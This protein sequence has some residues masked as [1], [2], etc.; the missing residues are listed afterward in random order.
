VGNRGDHLADTALAWNEAPSS[1]FFN[2]VNQYGSNQYNNYV[3]SAADA[4]AYGIKYPYPGFCAPA[5]AAIAPYPQVAAWASTYWY[6]Y[7]LVYVGLPLGQS[8][9]NSM[10]VDVVKRGGRGLTMDLSYTL[11]RQRGDTFSAQQEYNGY[12]TPVQDFANLSQAANT[13]TGYDQTHIV[14]GFVSYELPFGRG[15]HWLANQ[16]RAVNGIVG[17]WTLAGIVTYYSGQP[18][19]VSTSSPNYYPLW[20]NI[21]PNFN[22]SG[23]SGPSDPGKYQV[24]QPNQPVPSGDFYMPASVAGNPADG[25][26][27]KGPAAISA[28]RCPG[29]ANENV[30]ALKYFG[31]GPEARYRLSFRAEFYNV[32]NRHSYEI[33]GC[34]GTHA[35]IGADNFGQIIGVADNPRT[36]QFAVRFE[37]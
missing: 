23:F 12:Y 2:L 29:G 25:Q 4:A 31:F 33:N 24:P 20:G 11:S 21:L 35:T 8:S 36:G 37:Y 1:Q 27:G 16:R 26:L 28:L 6:Y 14:K 32:F 3:C 19:E 18:F 15:R 22:L 17:G 5:L 30:S 10:V 9:Y 34:A 7:N 13:I